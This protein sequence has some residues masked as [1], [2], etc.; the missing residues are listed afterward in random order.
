M[1]DFPC[2]FKPIFGLLIGRSEQPWC[3]RASERCMF[4]LPPFSA[5]G[6]LPRNIAKDTAHLPW[7]L[8][9][10]LSPEIPQASALSCSFHSWQKGKAD[11]SMSS[12]RW[13]EGEPPPCSLAPAWPGALA[14]PAAPRA[15][16]AATPALGGRRALHGD[17]NPSQRPGVPISISAAA[18]R[19][20]ASPPPAPPLALQAQL[21]LHLNKT[22][23]KTIRL[24]QLLN[25]LIPKS[26]PWVI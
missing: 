23:I 25:H 8:G 21:V 9:S 6:A 11:S 7:G 17:T 22:I 26:I 14:A 20:A 12:G 18:A 13:G 19:E 16:L 2:I 24:S 15:S 4:Y 3:F 10:R 5:H 1:Q